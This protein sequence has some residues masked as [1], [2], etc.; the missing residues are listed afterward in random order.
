MS[1]RAPFNGYPFFRQDLNGKVY[2]SESI[3]LQIGRLGLAR[4]WA[5]Y[6]GPVELAN[7]LDID[8]CRSNEPALET[9]EWW[10]LFETKGHGESW[11]KIGF[12]RRDP[13]GGDGWGWV[14]NTQS[15]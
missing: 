8:P 9:D 3:G 4:A 13:H 10:P 7:M 6:G 2:S 15:I 11:Q 12:F 1:P 14:G 5:A